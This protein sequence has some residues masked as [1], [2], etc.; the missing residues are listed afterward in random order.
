[1]FHTAGLRHQALPMLH[2][3][4]FQRPT[5]TLFTAAKLRRA[6]LRL[7]TGAFILNSAVGKLG[8]DEK[9]AANLHGM[10][11]RAYPVL[12]K[13][14]PQSFLKLLV[15]GE[16]TVATALLLPIIPARL[17]GLALIGFSGSLLSMYARIPFLHDKYLRPTPG[18]VPIAK[19]IWMLGIGVSLVVD[20]LHDRR[21]ARAATAK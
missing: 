8:G 17:A 16:L 5:S 12:A 7:A 10:A 20:S 13:A 18:G 15:A 4:G 21:G 14:E 11:A 1:M 3:A 6:P 19:D 9:T 2:R